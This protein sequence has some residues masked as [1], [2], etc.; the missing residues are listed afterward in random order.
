MFKFHWNY[1][2]QNFHAKNRNYWNS[3]G[4]W[5]CSCIRVWNTDHKNHMTGAPGVDTGSFEHSFP[6]PKHNTEPRSHKRFWCTAHECQII[7]QLSPNL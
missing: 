5:I 1:Q 2:Y 4:F 3:E 6:N 7:M